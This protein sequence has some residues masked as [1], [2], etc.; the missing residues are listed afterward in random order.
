MAYIEE[1]LS[2]G[3]VENGYVVTVRVPY[4]EEDEMGEVPMMH[5]EKTFYVKDEKAAA[6]KMTELLPVLVNKMSAEEEYAKAFKTM[7]GE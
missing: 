2:V 7:A 5:R 1:M 4:K 3:A 6:K